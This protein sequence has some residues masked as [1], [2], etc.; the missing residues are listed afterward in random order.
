MQLSDLGHVS[1]NFN[2]EAQETIEGL[3]YNCYYTIYNDNG[4]VIMW[5]LHFEK[6]T[7]QEKTSENI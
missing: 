1:M 4:T 3:V 5:K 6:Y 2:P 7:N